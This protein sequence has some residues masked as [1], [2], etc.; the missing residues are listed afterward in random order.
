LEGT[1]TAVPKFTVGQEPALLPIAP[2][3]AEQFAEVSAQL[4]KKGQ[5]HSDQRHLDSGDCFG[6]RYHLRHK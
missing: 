4:I 2:D 1:A 3:V 6:L 5:A